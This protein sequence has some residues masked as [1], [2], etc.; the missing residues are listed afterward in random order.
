M[1]LNNVTLLKQDKIILPNSLHENIICMGH[2]GSL[3]Q[4]L[5]S[6]CYIKDLDIKVTKYIRDFSYC[7]M[8]TKK[9]T[10]H[11]IE[12]NSVPEKCWEETSV[13]LF[14]PL[15]SSHHVLVVQDLASHYPVAKI[16]KSTNA[17][18]LETLT[19]YLATR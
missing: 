9:T 10:K 7:Q 2:N 14:G 11:P 13:D 17:K 6:Y 4:H 19:T 18:S 3:K 5:K 16:V 1:V 15:I 12:P 8:F